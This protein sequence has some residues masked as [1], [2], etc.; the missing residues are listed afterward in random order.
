MAMNQPREPEPQSPAEAGD[1]FLPCG[2][3]LAD[4]W[5]Q[6]DQDPAG[7]E[8]W[9]ADP[10][11]AECRHC[12]AALEDF[13]L[14]RD[15]V[16]RDVQETEAD[17]EADAARLTASIMDVVRQELR[18]GRTLALGET[19]EDA[20]MYE[21]VA[22]RIFR[23]AAE[24]VPGVRAGSCRISP[25]PS[26]HTQARTPAQVRIEVSVDITPDLQLTAD[27]VRR[28]IA[29]AAEHDLGMNI[30]SI[31]VAITDIHHQ[32]SGEEPR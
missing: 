30:A 12:A 31:D 23:T 22:A 16:R 17:W 20:W 10:H 26:S 3:D 13:T 4:L 27:R 11:T 21:A 15:A 19:D 8:P 32:T 29:T 18:P 25:T 14:L 6:Q 5:D 1:A 2:R 28:R 7:L 9:S 24:L